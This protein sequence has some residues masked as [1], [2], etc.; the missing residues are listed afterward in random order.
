LKEDSKG[1]ET[2]E[3][4]AASILLNLS[5]GGK[6]I[7]EAFHLLGN[8]YSYRGNTIEIVDNLDVQV[9]GHLAMIVVRCL[10][11]Q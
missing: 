5:K 6:S 10:H 3:K 7:R 2:E 11:K 1:I 4:V 8:I 9:M